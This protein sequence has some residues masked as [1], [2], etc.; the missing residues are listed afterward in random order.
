MGLL[1]Y[2]EYTGRLWILGGLSSALCP[3]LLGSELFGLVLMASKDNVGLLGSFSRR[4]VFS[5]A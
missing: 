1:F 4:S 5:A 3:F 2:G